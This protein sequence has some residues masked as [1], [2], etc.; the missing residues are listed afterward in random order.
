MKSFLALELPREIYHSK[1]LIKKPPYLP[2]YADLYHLHQALFAVGTE[3][4]LL[5]DNILM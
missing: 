5:D 1:E 3:D 2:L 4:A